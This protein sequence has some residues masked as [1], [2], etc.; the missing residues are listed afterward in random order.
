MQLIQIFT[1]ILIGD[2]QILTLVKIDKISI[3]QL[4]IYK[5]K[6]IFKYFKLKNTFNIL[7]K[8]YK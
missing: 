3:R 4:N 7:Q 6:I 8:S 1:L 2:Q 5:L